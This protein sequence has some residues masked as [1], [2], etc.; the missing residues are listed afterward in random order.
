MDSR[1]DAAGDL[2]L[3]EHQDRTLWDLTAIEQANRIR[4]SAL[5]HMSPGPF[6]LQAII[7]AHDANAPTAA[8]TDWATIAGTYARLERIAASLVVALNHAVAVSMADGPRAGLALLETITALDGYHLFHAARG[9]L[10]V[11]AGDSIAAA[12]ALRRAR[13]LAANP[14]EQRHLDRRLTAVAR[15]Q[16][17][18]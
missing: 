5:S 18:L 2:V 6:Q 8:D 14:A 4:V 17:A 3:L 12:K 13:E 15:Q 10:L 9:E 1:T 16:S 7:A 11:Q